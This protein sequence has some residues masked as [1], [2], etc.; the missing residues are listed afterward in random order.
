MQKSPREGAPFVDP[1][2]FAGPVYAQVIMTG[3]EH[4]FGPGTA[5]NVDEIGRAEALMALSQAGN[6]GQELPC[7]HAPVLDGAG[8]AAVIT[9]SARAGERLA[10]VTQLHR[11]TAFGRVSELQHLAQLLTGDTLL[12]LQGCAV[13]VDLLLDQEFSGANVG[14]SEIQGAVGRV[15]AAPRPARLLVIPLQG[16]GQIVMHHPAPVRLV[17]A[18]SEG[19]RRDDDL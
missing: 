6:A 2:M 15:A 4:P 7:F 13:G 12:V 14:S 1:A 9:C 3:R 10:E 16:A 11:T 8:F 5:Q 17:D 19:N 18:H